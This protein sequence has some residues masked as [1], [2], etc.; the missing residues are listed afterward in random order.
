[1]EG[2]N[3]VRC[4]GTNPARLPD[5]HNHADPGMAELSTYIDLSDCRWS[6]SL[7]VR[8]VRQCSIANS[9]EEVSQLSCWVSYRDR[10][11]TGGWTITPKPLETSKNSGAGVGSYAERYISTYPARYSQTRIVFRL[12]TVKYVL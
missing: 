5:L 12:G 6:E 3:R 9:E 8:T 10:R 2:E 11:K 1:M 4:T 7:T